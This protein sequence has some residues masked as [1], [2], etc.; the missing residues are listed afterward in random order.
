MIF[1]TEASIL[2]RLVDRCPS[3][4]LLVGTFEEVNLTDDAAEVVAGQV[5][6]TEIQPAGEVRGACAAVLLHYAFSV[7]CDI[8][9]ASTEQKTAAADLFEQAAHALVGWEYAPM[10]YPQ[11]TQG[12]STEFNGRVLRLS[13][14]FSLPA[15]LGS[16]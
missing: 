14:G 5:F 7:Y 11:L 1:D 9:R 15:F 10:R 6:L 12:Q 3:G 8:A 16:P 4:S 13:F 2:A